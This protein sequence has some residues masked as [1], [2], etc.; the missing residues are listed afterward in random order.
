M[1]QI[2][3]QIVVLQEASRQ[4]AHAIQQPLGQLRLNAC[5]VDV[6]FVDD[7]TRVMRNSKIITEEHII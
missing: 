4:A 3:R 5:D 7:R 2:R 6:R 1:R